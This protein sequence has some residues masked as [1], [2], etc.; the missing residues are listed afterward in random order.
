M[1]SDETLWI[2]RIDSKNL[3]SAYKDTFSIVRV[4]GKDIE[5]FSTVVGK[6]IGYGSGYM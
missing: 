1:D 2:P 6:R 4:G 3:V 5:R